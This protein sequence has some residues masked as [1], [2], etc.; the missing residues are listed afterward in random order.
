MDQ[1]KRSGRR[2]RSWLILPHLGLAAVGLVIWIVY[3]AIDDQGLNWL[4]FIVLLPTAL[5]GWGMFA[6]WLLRRRSDQHTPAGAP[7]SANDAPAE[8]RFPVS[9]VAVHGLFAVATVILVLIESAAGES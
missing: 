1:A 8:Q 6:I 9:L 4:A 2:I 3:V 5:L 7:A